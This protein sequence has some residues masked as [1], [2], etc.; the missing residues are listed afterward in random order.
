MELEEGEARLEEAVRLTRVVRLPK[1]HLATFGVTRLHYYVVTKPLY[2]DLVPGKEEAVVREGN[3]VSERPA[4][5]TPNYMLNLEGFGEDAR[6]YMDGLVQRFGPHSPG[7]LYQY[8]N[9]PAGM[10]IVGDEV[11]VV[12]E[13]IAQDLD[14][15]N[16]DM[17]S[18]IQGVD[19]LWDVS[20][21][22]F[23]YEYTAASFSSNLGEMQAM[24]LL[25]PDPG[26]ELPRGGLRRIEEL[27]GQVS[28]GLDPAVLKRELDR[29]GLFERYQDRFFDAVMRR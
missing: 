15:R 9:E 24:G 2:T 21:L 10:E 12:A 20:L 6:K 5:V 25:D 28:Q 13:R 26:T 27:F 3:V 7:L 23:I 16:V 1:Q 14:G 19:E 11:S 22:K 29:W 18:V 8:R 4:V 17:A